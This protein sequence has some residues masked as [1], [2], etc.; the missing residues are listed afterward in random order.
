MEMTVDQFIAKE[1]AVWGE[2]YI[3]SLI[4]SG[5]TPVLTDDGNYK[6]LAPI[7]REVAVNG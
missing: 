3:F 5:Y 2:D 4:D 6:W 1:I 7:P